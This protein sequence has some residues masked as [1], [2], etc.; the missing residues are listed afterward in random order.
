MAASEQELQR[1]G[2]AIGS[3]LQAQYRWGMGDAERYRK[4][5]AELLML[6]PDVLVAA[7]A[8]AVEALQRA[9]VPCRLCLPTL[10]T[11]SAAA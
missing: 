10:R 2:W 9:L 5:S 6:K 7:G 8:P 11:P 4:Y 1:L 3:N